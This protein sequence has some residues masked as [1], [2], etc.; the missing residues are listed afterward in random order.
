MQIVLEIF[1]KVESPWSN[2]ILRPGRD[3]HHPHHGIQPL[4]TF[5]S[6]LPV[7]H[8]VDLCY[9]DG[10]GLSHPFHSFLRYHTRIHQ[11]TR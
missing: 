7:G 8:Y 1:I 11:P 3:N 6:I 10:H 4:P 9:G 2:N 5:S